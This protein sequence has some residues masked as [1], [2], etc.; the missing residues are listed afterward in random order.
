MTVRA[1]VFLVTKLSVGIVNYSSVRPWAVR[2]L[3]TSKWCPMHSWSYD[4]TL[5]KKGWYEYTKRISISL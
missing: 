3:G 1:V 2:G 5:L 4:V